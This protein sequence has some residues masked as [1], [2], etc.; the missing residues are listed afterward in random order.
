[1]LLQEKGFLKQ[2][3]CFFSFFL[4]P[5]FFFFPLEKSLLCRL[6]VCGIGRQVRLVPPVEERLGVFQ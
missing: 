5:T 2:C 1:M 3:S 6:S 4:F